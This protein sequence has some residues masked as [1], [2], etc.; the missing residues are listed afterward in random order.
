MSWRG[1]T[2][3]EIKLPRRK[4]H[5]QSEAGARNRAGRS[6]IYQHR[7]ASCKKEK[8]RHIRVRGG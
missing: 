3:G 4:N 1:N 2:K 5:H 6:A 8:P 7:V